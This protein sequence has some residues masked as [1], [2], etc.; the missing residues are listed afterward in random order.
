MCFHWRFRYVQPRKDEP[1]KTLDQQSIPSSVTL[2]I[3]GGYLGLGAVLFKIWESDWT[4]FG[5]FYFCFVT[6]STIGLGDFVPGECSRR[7]CAR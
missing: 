2:G 7:L 1:L 6:L 3:V 4:T 5:A